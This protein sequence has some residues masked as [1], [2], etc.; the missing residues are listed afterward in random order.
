M[1]EKIDLHTLLLAQ[2]LG[3]RYG[4]HPV[5]RNVSFNLEPG[6]ILGLV[7]R[8]GAGKSTL[9][10][11]LLGLQG[12]DHGR[13]VLFGKPSHTINDND[14][15]ALAYVPQ[16]T[17]G[18]NWMTIGSMMDFIAGLYP[19]WDDQLVNR[20][21][22][23]WDL[24]RKQRLLGLSPGE[25]QQ[26]AIIRALAT[27]PRLL[28]L[29]EPASALDPVARRTLLG[30]IINL[31]VEEKTTVLFSTHI[32]SDL[33]RI[34]S[35]VLLLN[36]GHSV[37]HDSLDRIKDD[38]LRIWWPASFVLPVSPLPDELV[39]RP[40]KDGSWN[41]IVRNKHNIPNGLLPVP[42]VLSSLN[43]EELFVELTT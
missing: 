38:Y 23:K 29:D 40:L 6:S 11:C 21:L 5:L 3:K 1:T 10:E 42:A 33:E 4:Q 37:L 9:I 2:D 36:N 12:L 14:K 20:L 16:K 39:R 18:F 19:R 13:A 34:A 24:N 15:A 32:I 41:L 35:H 25:R 22:E 43:L 7:G 30:E 8:N 28:V 27:R 17:D 31:A 26:V